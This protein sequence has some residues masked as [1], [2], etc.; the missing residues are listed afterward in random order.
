MYVGRRYIEGVHNTLLVSKSEKNS[1]ETLIIG[2]KLV[3]MGANLVLKK[4]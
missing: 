1:F 4:N 3:C 2:I